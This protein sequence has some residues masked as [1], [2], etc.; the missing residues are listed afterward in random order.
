MKRLGLIALCSALLASGCGY[1]YSI[2]RGSK[3]GNPPKGE[4]RIALEGS[5]PE[6]VREALGH[7]EVEVYRDLRGNEVVSKET[8]V[9]RKVTNPFTIVSTEEKPDLI[10]S[11]SRSTERLSQRGMV[12]YEA[13]KTRQITFSLK[14]TEKETGKVLMDDHVQKFFPPEKDD[15][16]EM[17]GLIFLAYILDVSAL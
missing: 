2:L 6:S 15:D 10:V 17:F 7:K 16:A 5:F 12:D 14:V 13:P 4:V 3:F 9:L 8:A 1:R 11:G